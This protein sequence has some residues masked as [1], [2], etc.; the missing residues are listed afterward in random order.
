MSVIEG[1]ARQA[2]RSI[3]GGSRRKLR[4][5]DQARDAREWSAAAVLYREFLSATPNRAD[6]WVQYGHALKESGIQAEAAYR[7]AISLDANIADFH[8]QLGHV[9]KLQGRI[10]EA[11]DAYQRANTIWT[12]LTIARLRPGDLAASRRLL[13]PRPRADRRRIEGRPTSS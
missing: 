10:E 13:R 12:S 4:Q 11:H 1:I 3:V 5:A 6:I 8:L 9:L 7:Q 2:G